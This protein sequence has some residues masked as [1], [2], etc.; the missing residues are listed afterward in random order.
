MH[1]ERA[2]SLQVLER[3]EPGHFKYLIVNHVYSPL[4]QNSG[5]IFELLKAHKARGATES[6]LLFAVHGEWLVV[7][8]PEECIRRRFPE[9][10]STVLD[11]FLRP[12][13]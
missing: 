1:I 3:G 6:R 12:A 9:D 5:E 2:L 7:G 13:R 4:A 8:P 11:R 10:H